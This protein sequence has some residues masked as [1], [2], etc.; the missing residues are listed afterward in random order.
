MFRVFLTVLGFV[1][2][3]GLADTASA[4]TFHL[5][6]G[7][8]PDILNFVGWAHPDVCVSFDQRVRVKVFNNR[9]RTY[10]KK[11]DPHEGP[12]CFT[13]YPG[14]MKLHV[15]PQR[16]WVNVRIERAS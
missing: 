13:V 4:K 9:V 16:D 1:A 14:Q 12:V 6:K 8:D 15:R 11:L 7:Q 2:L 5:T 3:I 10:Y